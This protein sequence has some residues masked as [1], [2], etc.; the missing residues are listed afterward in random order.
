MDGTKE[1]SNAT[2]E[3]LET[4]VEG[5]ERAIEGTHAAIDELFPSPPQAAPGPRRG[6]VRLTTGARSPARSQRLE[7]DARDARHHG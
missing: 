7:W 2:V 4:T 6:F 5:M 3:G 1:G